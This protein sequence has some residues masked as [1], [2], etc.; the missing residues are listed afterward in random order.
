MSEAPPTRRR[1]PAEEAR[2]RILEAAERE[3]SRVGPAGLKLTELAAGLGISHPAILH[4]FGSREGLVS[5][6]VRKA[7]LSLNEQLVGVL[8]ASGGTDGRGLLN[9][10][11]DFYGAHGQARLLAW[12][13]LADARRDDTDAQPLAALAEELN[14]LRGGGPAELDEL[15]FRIQVGAFALFGEALI[16]RDVRR[17]SG[18][19]ETAEVSQRFRRRL[20]AMLAHVGPR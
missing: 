18:Q 17:D 20:L 2:R 15:L 6:V 16:G 8:R 9:R 5:A 7:V 10:V 13:A 1:L 4:H 12:L 19:P 11:V 3:L 14:R